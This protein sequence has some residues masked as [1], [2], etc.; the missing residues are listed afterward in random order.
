M[1][2]FPFAQIIAGYPGTGRAMQ[3]PKDSW[4]FRIKFFQPKTISE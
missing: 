4:L 1:V 3:M 2:N